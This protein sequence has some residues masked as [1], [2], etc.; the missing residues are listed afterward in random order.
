MDGAW[1]GVTPTRQIHMAI[2]NE[3]W[4]APTEGTVPISPD[5]QSLT[6]VPDEIEARVI[7]EVE[8]NVFM[9]LDT[10]VSLRDWLDRKIAD[11]EELSK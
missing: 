1:G 5:G 8:A 3:R 10:A 11:L 9:S 6:E 7:R 4:D 2:Y